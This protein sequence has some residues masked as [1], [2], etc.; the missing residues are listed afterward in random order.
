[1]YHGVLGSYATCHMYNG[2]FGGDPRPPTAASTEMQQK[3]INACRALKGWKALEVRPAP[4][5]ASREEC[6]EC[7]DDGSDVEI[8]VTGPDPEDRVI[9]ESGRESG[10]E[11]GGEVGSESGSEGGGE[12]DGECSGESGSESG[13]ESGD[14][15]DDDERGGKT[16]SGKLEP[17]SWSPEPEPQCETAWEQL[18]EQ[19]GSGGGGS[20]APEPEPQWETAWEQLPEQVGGGG[21]GSDGGVDLI[22]LL[23]SLLE[24]WVRLVCIVCM[25]LVRLVCIV[26]MLL[27]EGW[28]LLYR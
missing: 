9:Y 3:L 11:G 27:R 28:L 7:G 6:K 23:E 26:C 17:W 18:P 21:G 4:S 2:M 15:S 8:D 25:L 22:V 13:S 24:L 5:S 20:W 14:E 1:M 10:G 12:S 16:E 19:V